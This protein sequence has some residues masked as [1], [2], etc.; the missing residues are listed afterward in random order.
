M[1][2]DFYSWHDLAGLLHRWWRGE[3]PIGAVLMAIA[4]ASARITY[5][6][7]GWKNMAL[8]GFL[9]GA[10]TLTFASMFEYLNL[11]QSLSIGVGGAV[12]FIG[13]RAIRTFAM[14]IISRK[15]GGSSGN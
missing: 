4:M 2:N 7:G 6:G 1:N 12:G 9:C 10:L 5:C 13:V 8:E 15:T 3:T 14:S 11:P